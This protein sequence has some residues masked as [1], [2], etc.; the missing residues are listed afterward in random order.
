MTRAKICQ[1]EGSPCG[2]FEDT[3][4]HSKINWP[5][6]PNSDAK[7][8]LEVPQNQS[9]SFKLENKVGIQSSNHLLRD[10]SIKRTRLV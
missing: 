8:N 2:R 1:R 10:F 9:Y 3:K 7:N 4:N 6:T 5:L